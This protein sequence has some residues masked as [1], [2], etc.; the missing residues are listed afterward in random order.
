M[1]QGK[2]FSLTN[3]GVQALPF[4]RHFFSSVVISHPAHHLIFHLRGRRSPVYHGLRVS[5]NLV[6]V[7]REVGHLQGWLAAPWSQPGHDHSQSISLILWWGYRCHRLMTTPRGRKKKLLS[8][9]SPCR[10]RRKSLPE[11]ACAIS[12]PKYHIP[13]PWPFTG[14]GL[15]MGLT[16]QKTTGHSEKGRNPGEIWILLGRRSVVSWATRVAAI[17]LLSPVCGDGVESSGVDLL[18]KA[19]PKVAFI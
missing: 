2:S 5:E 12:P 4:G 15:V 18:R 10:W 19:H 14:K 1:D 17:A 16:F 13:K 8:V 9:R 7:W 3:L 6:C 11:A